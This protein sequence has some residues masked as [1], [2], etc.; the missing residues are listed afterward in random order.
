M[1]SRS[2]L[3]ACSIL[4]SSRASLG[5]GVGE[6]Y[7]QVV[8]EKGPP[9]S[10]MQAGTR[11]IVTYPDAVVKFDND[12][13]VS[14]RAVAPPTP[15]PRAAA[16]APAAAPAQDHGFDTVPTPKGMQDAINRIDAALAQVR[17]IVNQ[18]VESQPMTEELKYKAGRFNEGWFHPG[19]GIPDFIGADIR[20]TQELKSYS[21]EEWCTSNLTPDRVFREQDCEFNGQTKFFYMDRNLPKKRLTE[22]EMIE[23]NRLYHLI[24]AY[25]EYLARIG[26]PWVP[27]PGF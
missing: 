7:S 3:L 18:P 20:K 19:A 12:V 16:V 13:V 15:T 10:E 11:R 14:V 8:A 2:L 9:K 1:K 26:H 22:S 24:G 23:I 5:L 25:A 17:D 27:N 4:L 6:T 21:D